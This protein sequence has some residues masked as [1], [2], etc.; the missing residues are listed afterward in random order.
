MTSI[1]KQDLCNRW[2]IL[3]LC[4]K[5][6]LCFLKYYTKAV[7]K[8]RKSWGEV[9]EVKEKLPFISSRILFYFIFLSFTFVRRLHSGAWCW[10]I[11]F[12]GAEWYQ[13]TS[14]TRRGD[15]CCSRRGKRGNAAP[16]ARH[17]ST[18]AW[19]KHLG[20][21]LFS[22]YPNVWSCFVVL[23]DSFRVNEYLNGLCNGT[24]AR[25]L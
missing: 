8:R 6:H 12:I 18:H 9:E 7:L 2:R 4:S 16:T 24:D 23:F 15:L 25:T 22:V 5:L 1:L 19:R 17:R 13:T 20:V 10:K 21:N 14:I 11:I 3:I